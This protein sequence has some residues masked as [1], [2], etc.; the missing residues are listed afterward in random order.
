MFLR[1]RFF[2]GIM[3]I[4]V[5][6]FGP[7]CKKSNDDGDTVSER[8]R[9]LSAKSWKWSDVTRT[10]SG[11]TTSIL[12]TFQ[13]CVRDNLYNFQANG[14]YS[15]SE[16]ASKCNTTDPD[17]VEQG[18]WSFFNNENNLKVNSGPFEIEYGIAE[19]TA[20]SMRLTITDNTGGTAR[21]FTYIYTAQ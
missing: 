14:A 7:S 21:V 13:V 8:S 20:S 4:F 16:G 5:L 1:T 15:A 19:L 10:E 17:I 11:S 6:A 2:V 12:S 18:N 3:A 9:L